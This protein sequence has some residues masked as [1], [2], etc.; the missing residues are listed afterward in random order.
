MHTAEKELTHALPL[1]AKAA[2]SKDLKSLLR[3]HL[4]ETKGR[5][6]ALEN[7]A[8]SLGRKLPSKSCKPMTKLIGQGVKVMAKR[9]FSGDKEQELI[10]V[11]RKIE[12]FEIDNY[13]P[14]VAQAARLRFTY[15]TALLTSILNQEKL[16]SELLTA[17]GEGKGPL[18]KLVKGVV[19]AHAGAE[20]PVAEAA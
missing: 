19:L 5:V 14:L 16:A 6:R 15:E 1:V 17:L 18:D 4:K 9:I 10:G 3:F 20:T 2:K 13:T 7:V 12:Q 11:G 8:K